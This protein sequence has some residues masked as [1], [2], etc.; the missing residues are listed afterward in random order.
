MSSFPCLTLLV[1]NINVFQGIKSQHLIIQFLTDT[2]RPAKSVG[3]ARQQ[4]HVSKK[5]C[6]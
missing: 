3:T 1:N 4:I 2:E 6:G 5:E